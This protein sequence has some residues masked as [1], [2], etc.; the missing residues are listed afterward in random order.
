MEYIIKLIQIAETIISWLFIIWV[1]LFFLLGGKINIEMN[2]I[3][4]TIDA[5]KELIGR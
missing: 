5:I 4:P 3:K 2:G 1:A